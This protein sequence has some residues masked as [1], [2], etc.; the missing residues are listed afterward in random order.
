M[1][2]LGAW[3]SV[4]VRT[5]G[6]NVQYSFGYDFRDQELWIIEVS[7]GRRIARLAPD[8]TRSEVEPI[9]R[10]IRQTP[11]LLHACTEAVRRLGVAK[12]PNARALHGLI[13]GALK[14]MELPLT[15]DA[16]DRNDS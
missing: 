1:G 3:K 4:L 14:G 7:T 2:S 15:D 10:A 13:Y 9:G 8:L 5:G 6:R 11:A 16:L 12:H